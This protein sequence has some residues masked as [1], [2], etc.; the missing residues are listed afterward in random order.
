MGMLLF[1]CILP[2]KDV[3]INVIF[4]RSFNELEVLCLSF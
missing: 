2:D 1:I 4:H 3:V